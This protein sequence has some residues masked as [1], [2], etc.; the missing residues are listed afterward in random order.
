[1]H[2]KNGSIAHPPR[3]APTGF[4]TGTGAT[5]ASCNLDVDVEKSLVELGLAILVFEK[6]RYL[7]VV[8]TRGSTLDAIVVV[9]V[10]YSGGETVHS[11]VC[12]GVGSRS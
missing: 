6:V 2:D 7:Y 5:T 8:A 4:L 11:S 12:S 9:V 10:L 3:N 1:M